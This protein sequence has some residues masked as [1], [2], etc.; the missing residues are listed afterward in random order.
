[1]QSSKLHELGTSTIP[2]L[3]VDIKL[4]DYQK[5][6]VDSTL[7]QL[8]YDRKY[9]LMKDT[10][11]QER[12]KEANKEFGKTLSESHITADTPFCRIL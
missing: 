5:K 10:S 11:F 6:L 2:N 3:Q 7:S 8:R 1:M 12:F 4:L 9:V